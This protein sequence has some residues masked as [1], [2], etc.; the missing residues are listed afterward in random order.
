MQRYL[1]LVQDVYGNALK[2]AT[3][4]V[5]NAQGALATL[6]SDNGVTPIA[7]P[8]TTDLTGQCAFYAANGTYSITSSS[9]NFAGR[10]DSGVVL[11]DPA[12]PGAVSRLT[13]DATDPRFAGGADATFTRD[14]FPAI[15]AALAYVA[16]LGGGEVLLPPGKYKLLTP[17][18]MSVTGVS[19]AGVASNS[20]HDGGTTNYPVS[21]VYAGA[22]TSSA[23][24]TVTST[25]PTTNSMVENASVSNLVIDASALAATCLSVK[26]IRNSDYT[27][28]Y[29]KN[30]TTQAYLLSAFVKSGSVEA[31]D[32]QGC[33]F[34][35]CTWRAVDTAAVQNAN[36]F[37]LT[38]DGPGTAN[39]NVSFNTFELCLG[40]TYSGIGWVL[41][42]ADNNHFTACRSVRANGTSVVGLSIRG[43][44]T[45][46]WYGFSCSG[47]NAIEI[48]GTASGYFANPTGNVFL[49]LDDG[50]GMTVPSYDMSCTAQVH[51]A[52][53]GWIALRAQ[54][55]VL[56][57]SAADV[58]T[59]LGNLGTETLRLRN[60]SGNHVV[61]T[62][63]TAAQNWS[64][65]ID[66]STGNYRLFSATGTNGMQ[67][68]NS[69]N[70]KIGFLGV[71]PVVRQTIASAATDAATT[72]TLAN[73][74]RTAMLA[75]GLGA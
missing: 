43:A 45:N 28:I 23:V 14:S 44:D 61:L 31:P 39:A 53:Q 5:Y 71:T 27:D 36:G 12:D 48:R 35:R 49:N 51:F 8:I 73:S 18:V 47:A 69:I 9:T 20:F 72:Q 70:G 25:G 56:A 62:N 64:Y 33:R 50:N 46:Y 32:L 67:F 52:K 42:D 59:E 38:S 65:N 66:G 57:T 7:N 21:L 13:F 26:S 68:G 15:T 10:T 55:M 58:A 19:L 16:T 24:V 60:G 6:Y 17:L 2:G 11:F 54:R 63:G 3:V 41:A 34:T 74:L 40:E 1:D 75:L 29:A 22:P 37:V 4:A 30:P